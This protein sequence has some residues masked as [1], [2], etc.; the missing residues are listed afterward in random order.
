[1]PTRGDADLIISKLVHEAMLIG[2]TPRPVTCK[3][4]LEWLRLTNPVVAI[5]LNVR[6]QLVDPLQDFAV[7]R[8][9][10]QIV[11]PGVLI[12][13]EQHVS[14]SRS[15]RDARRA[16]TPAAPWRP[17]NGARLLAIA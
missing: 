16:R 17:A 1:M 10:P 11:R 14:L 12:P 15:A 7:L 5:S 4:V 3:I 8:L 13:D 9:P 2:D 6:E